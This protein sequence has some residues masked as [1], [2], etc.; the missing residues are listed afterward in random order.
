[1]S[2]APTST[3]LL[4]VCLDAAA[5]AASSDR[6]RLSRLAERHAATICFACRE[7]GHAARDCPN[8]QLEDAGDG[9]GSSRPGKAE[10]QKLVGICYRYESF[11]AR[12]IHT[13]R[14]YCIL[15]VC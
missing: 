11:D 4:F 5:R 15:I 2:R 6:R 7:R 8:V 12:L 1:M 14:R 10:D 13:F 9:T 3:K